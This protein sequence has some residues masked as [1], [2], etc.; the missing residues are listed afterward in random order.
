M[1]LKSQPQ[2]CS[3]TR[4]CI[5]LLLRSL[6]VFLNEAD[7]RQRADV[8][9]EDRFCFAMDVEEFGIQTITCVSILPCLPTS[10][11]FLSGFQ[12]V[13]QCQEATEEHG[14]AAGPELGPQDQA[15]QQIC[16]GQRGEAEREQ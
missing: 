14:E 7:G 11:L 8:F 16:S 2:R 4:L 10:F 5:C 9:L 3:A 15:L 1:F 13:R 12:L 6:V